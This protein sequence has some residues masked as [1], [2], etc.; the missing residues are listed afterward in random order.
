MEENETSL[1]SRF[2]RVVE[3]QV[4]KEVE[5]K[6]RESLDRIVSDVMSS[7]ALRVAT[8]LD[9]RTMGQEV[10]ITCRLDNVRS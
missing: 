1:E 10:V 2:I 3:Q 5:A 4:I 6:L 7:V 9:I 8:R